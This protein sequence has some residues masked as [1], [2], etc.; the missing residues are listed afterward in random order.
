M[1][2]ID[3]ELIMSNPFIVSAVEALVDVQSGNIDPDAVERNTPVTSRRRSP[4]EDDIPDLPPITSA[5]DLI[6]DTTIVT[7][8]ELV[9]GFL[10]R[11]SKG[12]IAST[13]KARKTWVLSDLAVSV[14]TGQ[15]WLGFTTT[16]GKVLLVNF[17]IQ[18]PF[19]R[20]RI[21]A[22]VRA[23]QDKAENPQIHD[24][25]NLDI[26]TLRG[27][28]L[29][30]DVLLPEMTRR[31][32]DSGYSLIIIDPIYKGMAGMDEN[33]AGD[34][35]AVCNGFE[36]LAVDTGAAVVY[37]HHFSKGNAATKS[38]IDRLSGSGVFGR[39]ADSI[40]LLTPHETDNCYQV[41]MILRNHPEQPLSVV[42]WDFPLMRR[43]EDLDPEAL[44]NR[45]G[46]P[47]SASP[48]QVK[49]LLEKG[50]LSHKDWKTTAKLELNISDATFNRCIKEL[51]DKGQV[52]QHER[53]YRIKPIPEAPPAN[54]PKTT[55]TTTSTPEDTLPRP[56]QNLTPLQA[57]EL[58]MATTSQ[59]TTGNATQ[60]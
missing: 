46:R 50:P 4:D 33:K 31:V 14:A 60:T 18:A 11:G 3:L 12:V 28:A 1:V 35:G 25:R 22:V 40:L 5:R 52:E 45:T 26:W 19:M 23:K 20:S 44:K 32:Q 21:S 47:I 39:D 57:P 34:I 17:E 7:P 56:P 15:P 48:N 55:A 41:E 2:K 13:S 58:K 53:Q 6:N 42:E 37:A 43:R 24:L 27:H 10:H 49:S 30:F 38:G 59:P 8:V 51:R 29:P 54:G 9:A 36:A 16:R